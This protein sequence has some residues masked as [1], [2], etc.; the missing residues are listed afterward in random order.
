M[1]KVRLTVKGLS[2]S[3]TQSGAYALILGEE[4]GGR[5]LPIIIGAFEAQSIAIAL[6]RSIDPPRPLTHDLFASFA[7]A[8]SIRLVEVYIHDLR[9]GVFHA[10]L[11]C[12]DDHGK[13]VA[14]D[15]R[16]SDAVAL[17]ARLDCPIYTERSILDKAGVIMDEYAGGNETEAGTTDDSLSDI[18]EPPTQA[19][20]WSMETIERLREL[21][22]AAVTNEDYELAARLRD[23]LDRRES[24]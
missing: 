6:E 10:N 16:T 18:E 3:Q 7:K 13:N 5:S 4:N 21:L 22:E 8:F 1:A 14:L 9:E 24:A 2:Y 23:E 15:A 19:E 20:R 11:L 17:A 12:E